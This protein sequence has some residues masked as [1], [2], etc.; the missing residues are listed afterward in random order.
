MDDI[1]A[2]LESFE[3]L[4]DF[5]AKTTLST[6]LLDVKVNKV[7]LLNMPVSNEQVQELISIAKPAEFGWKDQT[8]L[9]EQVR[10]VWKIPK[11]YVRISKREWD[12]S[13]LKVLDKL[14]VDLGLPSKSILKSEFHDMLIYEEGCFFKPHQDSEKE[15]GMVAT[16]I[17]VLPSEH[18]G[19]ELIVN[20]KNKQ[21][22]LKQKKSKL[23]KY[24]IAAF[25]ADCYHEVKP[26]VKG[27]RIA[28]T[29][30]LLLEKFTGNIN[31]LFCTNKN[32]KLFK[33]VDDH[34][35]KKN[36]EPSK[37]VYVLDHEYTQSGLSWDSL[38][39]KDA[40]CV[41]ALLGIAEKLN[42]DA[43]LTLADMK[44]CWD[45]E[46]DYDAYK[47]RRRSR[48]DDEEDYDDDE[49]PTPSYIMDT[50]IELKYWLDRQGKSFDISSFSPS[51]KE[52][53]WTG[54][55]EG[56]EPFESE[57]E[58]WMGNYGNTLDRWY[59]RAAIVLWKK[60][61]H[62]AIFFEIDKNKFVNDI[63]ELSRSQ[64][65]HNQVKTMLKS[66]A[67]YWQQYLTL[68]RN[69]NDA[70]KILD[71]VYYIEDEKISSSLLIHYDWSLFNYNNLIKWL[72]L[73]EL[74]SYSWLISV[75]S[76]LK[77]VS[78]SYGYAD[79]IIIEDLELL[80]EHLSSNE[81]H[82]KVSQILVKYQFLALKNNHRQ[83]SISRQLY[84]ESS[85][86]RCDEL[87]SLMSALIIKQDK[88]MLIECLQLI[89]ENPKTYP[90]LE[91]T[92]ACEPILNN[93][94]NFISNNDFV[95]YL[96]EDLNSEYALGCREK[97]DWHINEKA[98]CRCEYCKTLNEFIASETIQEK[99]WPLNE[100]FRGHISQEID[101]L[102]IPLKYHTEKKGRP[103]Q[104]ILK[105]SSALYKSAK[106]RF[107]N[108]NKA[109]DLVKT[110]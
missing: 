46:F 42:L 87:Y 82:K 31:N 38:K 47:Y 16:M 40:Q 99:N 110:I 56:F 4:G 36:D 63:F 21:H 94:K 26:V 75:L 95:K 53:C 39:N 97:N 92:L 50:E 9:D 96:N 17:M 37:I 106:I 7:G 27:N 45:C 107:N 108:L 13:M 70:D 48:Y 34:F 20:H 68:N 84:K 86:H 11:S 88:K 3:T 35:S 15:D 30:N 78:G 79:H 23:P 22:V 98:S 24:N 43:Y 6:K 67:N 64:N 76:E 104:L 80:I 90:V 62:H 28:L 72:D 19:G 66:A 52:V 33:A 81:N 1:I 93:I 77:K 55:N 25:Y 89:I 2:A 8:I 44:E 71:L 65:N 85:Q 59:H 74:Y 12:R 54:D 83:G 73:A 5:F 18:D 102:R 29:F 10:K 105:K 60:E 103:Y 51:Y 61:D 41:E 69:S 49:E 91:I 32:E 58:G 14:K 101:K 100:Q 57:Y 109:L